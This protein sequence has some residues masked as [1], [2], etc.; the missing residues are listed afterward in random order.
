MRLIYTIDVD[1]TDLTELEIEELVFAMEVQ[2]EDACEKDGV[3]FDVPI[4]SSRL[5]KKPQ[6]L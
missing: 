5:E 6:T 4:I 3:K 2:C 1:V